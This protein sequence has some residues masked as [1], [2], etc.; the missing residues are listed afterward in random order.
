MLF[1][2][3]IKNS[4]I[5]LHI[6]L[7]NQLRQHI[8]SGDWPA[9]TRLLSEPKLVERLGVSRATI[10]QAFDAG[11]REGLIYRVAGKGAFVAAHPIGAA[12][13]LVGFIIPQFHS[14][15]DSQLLLGAEQTL[16]AQRYQVLFCHTERLLEEENRCLHDLA[17]QR[18]D[19]II[20]WPTPSDDPNRALCQLAARGLPVALLDRTFAGVSA[21]VALADN[22]S[23][24]SA[25][26]RHLLDLGHRR[27]AF[28]AR[29]YLHLQSIAERFDAYCHAMRHAGLEP[30][31]PVLVG[32]AAEPSTHTTLHAFI[33]ATGNEIDAVSALLLRD[34][35]PT[36]FVAMNDHLALMAYKAATLIG[37]AIPRDLSIIGFDDL[38][39]L[40]QLHVP[41]TT[42]AQRP[43]DLG[44]TGARLL[45]DRLNGFR[46]A[47]RVQ[48]LPTRLIVRA[49]SGP[50]PTNEDS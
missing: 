23:G 46:G 38:D 34:E 16:K 37:L 49:T 26:I 18:I 43:F 45:L 35:R 8:L 47:P 14:T 6:Q 42:V 10:R 39:I 7:L 50:A 27:I 30:S 15:F 13:R 41:L 28:L 17:R 48:R 40:Q 3:L 9:H 44:A 29:P 1:A 24:V 22:A 32:A 5:P 36:A 21:D 19:G 33:T 12:H 25:A 31:A 4:P 20:I 2:P 11:E